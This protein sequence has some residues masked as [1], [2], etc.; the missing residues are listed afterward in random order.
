M[1][2]LYQSLVDVVQSMNSAHGAR[3]SRSD[4]TQRVQYRQSLRT[5]TERVGFVQ[6]RADKM[7]L[8]LPWEDQRLALRMRPFALELSPRLVRAE[9]KSLMIDDEDTA[10]DMP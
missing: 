7:N 4:R 10:T 2:H 9:L 6:L 8:G 3:D 1:R 5:E